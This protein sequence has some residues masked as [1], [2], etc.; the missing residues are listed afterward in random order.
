MIEKHHTNFKK[1]KIR[2]KKKNQV[3]HLF[4]TQYVL[5]NYSILTHPD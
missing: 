1:I 3:Q 5:E 4:D 2:F